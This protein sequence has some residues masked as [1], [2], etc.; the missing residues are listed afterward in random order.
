MEELSA[1]SVKELRKSLECPV[2]VQTPK[3]G[4]LYQCENGHILCSDCN[5]KVNQ[6]PECRANL[7]YVRIRSLFAEKQLE[8]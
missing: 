1:I 5:G 4:P 2:C 6:C 7:P 3:A 8:K